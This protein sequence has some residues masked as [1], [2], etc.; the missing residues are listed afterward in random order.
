MFSG[1]RQF[2]TTEGKT[3]ELLQVLFIALKLT[4]FI[5]WSWWW[6]LSPTLIPFVVYVV[7][8]VVSTIHE[9]LYEG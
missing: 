2:L 8:M 5:T 6:V 4:G 3:L 1:L 7:L 9:K